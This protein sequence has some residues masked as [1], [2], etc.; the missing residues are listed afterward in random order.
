MET[1]VL[2][3]PD[4]LKRG[5]V[6]RV[7]TR[8]ED[9]GI[10]FLRVKELIMPPRHCEELYAKFKGEPYLPRIQEFMTSGP[11]EARV[12]HAPHA[13]D[14]TITIVRS[15]VGSFTAPAAGTIRG[16]FGAVRE[17]NLIHASDS[18]SAAKVEIEIFFPGF[19]GDVGD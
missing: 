18:P 8:L 1:L 14:D 3:K 5:L 4:T 7:L 11:I 9:R 15:A 16:D 10:R 12:A 17:K 2:L 19:P 13:P 6:G